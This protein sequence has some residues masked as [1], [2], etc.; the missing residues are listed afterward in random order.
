M[1][2]SGT[3]RKTVSVG[4]WMA[5]EDA[6]GALTGRNAFENGL[7]DRSYCETPSVLA[8]RSESLHQK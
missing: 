8:P 4:N 1:A 2:V 3:A 5:R 6:D 7:L